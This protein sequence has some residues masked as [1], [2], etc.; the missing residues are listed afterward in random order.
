M[1]MPSE[2][3]KVLQEIKLIQKAVRENQLYLFNSGSTAAGAIVNALL[4]VAEQLAIM[5]D[6]IGR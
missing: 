5:N 4:M 1:T 6:R 2:Q 3:E